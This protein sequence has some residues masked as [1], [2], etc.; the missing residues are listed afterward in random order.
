[1][2]CT[3]PLGVYEHEG[4]LLLLFIDRVICSGTKGCVDGAPNAEGAPIL[5]DLPILI[6]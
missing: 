4:Y 5:G 2:G 1:M 3:V 6:S